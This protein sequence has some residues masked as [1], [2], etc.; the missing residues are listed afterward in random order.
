M[1]LAS[2]Q[3]SDCTASTKVCVHPACA[4][5][6][7]GA[8]G[9]SAAAAAT[10]CRSSGSAAAPRSSDSAAAAA[11]SVGPAAPSGDFAGTGGGAAAPLFDAMSL[12]SDSSAT[13]GGL[14]AEAPA[15][16]A[17]GADGDKAEPLLDAADASSGQGPPDPGATGAKAEVPSSLTSTRPGGS[18]AATNEGSLPADVLVGTRAFSSFSSGAAATQAFFLEPMRP[19]GEAAQGGATKLL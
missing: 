9:S 11:D 8:R 13:P 14:A 4:C 3:S 5:A 17:A 19:M 1:R 18:A 7:G 15:D 10:G 16:A 2:G 6:G 12:S